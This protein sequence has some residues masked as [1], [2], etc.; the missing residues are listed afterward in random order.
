M[1]SR[2]FRQRISRMISNGYVSYLR[3]VRKIDIGKDCNIS[4][5]ATL[6]RANP[7]GIHIGHNLRV[8]N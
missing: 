6:D 8:M 2:T 1:I 7:K 5:R 3:Y 4:W